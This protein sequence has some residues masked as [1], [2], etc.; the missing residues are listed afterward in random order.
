VGGNVAGEINLFRAALQTQGETQLL[1][2]L[3][4]CKITTF[5]D[6]PKLEKFPV[7]ISVCLSTG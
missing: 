7:S 4:L 3:R 2:K 6:L 5:L 1:L